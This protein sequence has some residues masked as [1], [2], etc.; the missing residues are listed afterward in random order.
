MKEEITSANNQDPVTD[1][2]NFFAWCKNRIVNSKSKIWH[3]ALLF[4]AFFAIELLA[5]VMLLPRVGFCLLFSLFWSMLF[6]A[7]LLMIPR[8]ASRII[9][10]I[11][12][13]VALIWTLSQLG[14]YQVFDKLMWLSALAYT[15]EGMMFIFDVLSKFPLLWWLAAIA[16]IALGVF[17]VWKYPDTTTGWRSRLPFFVICVVCV[18]SIALIPSLIFSLDGSPKEDSDEYTNVTSYE[19]TYES[20]YDAK[21]VYDLSG[22]YHMTFLDLWTFNIKKYTPEYDD[23]ITGDID[24]LNAYFAA[25][26]D[27][28]SNT[29][30]GLFAGKNVVYVLMESMDDWL[31][32]QDNTPTIY[33]LMNEGIQFTQF[34]TPGY[35][36]ARTLNTE[37][38]MNTGIYLP[39]NGEFVF[40]YT[41]NS[42]DQSIAAQFAHAGYT[43]YVFHYNSPE[44]YNRGQME[45]M[46][47]YEAYLSYEDYAETE[48]DLFNDCFLFDNAQIKDIF[49]RNG[50]TFNTIITRAAHLGYTYDEVL[51]V[52]ALKQYP[53]WKGSYPTEEEDVARL[54]ARLVD[55]MFTR[56]LK[57][58]ED[59]GQLQNTVIIGVTDHYTYG[60][61]DIPAL[62]YR[63]GVD[64][65]Q[66]LLLERTPCF[67]WSADGPSMKVD[68]TLQTADLVPTI[69]NLM[70]IE[71]PY[72]YLG[73]DAFDPNYEGY[74]LFP[75]GAWIS[76][77]VVCVVDTDGKYEILYNE[78]DKLLTP[79][80]ID[81]MCATALQFIQA[82]NK[83]V[84][85]NY[86]GQTS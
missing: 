49:F 34:F 50:P 30:T 79:E 21:K 60:C 47:G 24:E 16:L 66:K 51:S 86:Y 71:S 37:F 17:I 12:Y 57:E 7:I 85:T 65:D 62:Y 63:S 52:Y 33:R 82:S 9:F 5:F 70:G 25:R 42:F 78:K 61:R 44:Y 74:A 80:Y 28:G 27:N 10:G 14:Y 69:L 6:A 67:V 73:Q 3:F 76:D 83:L 32:T 58:L 29:M 20:L 1:S 81:E 18:V 54:K 59:A 26:P 68:K 8:K 72:K 56:L 84:T 4:I 43:G 15:G 39:S 36:S 19:D 31:I 38:C 46:V 41:D 23:E 53:D 2:K 55:D 22:I 64:T 77:G 45:P 40:N 75:N 13:A 11:F 48:D 35:G